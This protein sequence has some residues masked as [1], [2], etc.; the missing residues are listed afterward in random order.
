MGKEEKVGVLLG[1]QIFKTERIKEHGAHRAILG[2]EKP[3]SDSSGPSRL[4][5][6]LCDEGADKG[7]LWFL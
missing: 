3:F 6:V 4:S 5:M 7:L 2:K 1:S